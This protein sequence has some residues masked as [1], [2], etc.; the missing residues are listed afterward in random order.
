M[1]VLWYVMLCYNTSNNIIQ[2][3]IEIITSCDIIRFQPDRQ[4]NEISTKFDEIA[5]DIE[6]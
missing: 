1:F 5:I 6:A 4:S 2:E 3:S